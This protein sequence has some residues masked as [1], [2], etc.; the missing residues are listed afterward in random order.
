VDGYLSSIDDLN[1]HYI[2]HLSSCKSLRLAAHIDNP[3]GCEGMRHTPIPLQPDDLPN[4]ELLELENCFVDPNLVEFLKARSDR[5]KILRLVECMSAGSEDNPNLAE[6]AIPWAEF[7]SSVRNAGPVL[8]KF[9]MVN[10]I[11]NRTRELDEDMVRQVERD[12]TLRIFHYILLDD[13]YG[14]VFTDDT[15]ALEQFERGEDQRE[16]NTFMDLVRRN[17]EASSQ[18]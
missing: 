13:K 5:L 2:K 15:F 18:G 4:I 16:F 1:N 6:N 12:D 17:S 11:L 8:T 14:M 3:I 7:F 10:N 9:E